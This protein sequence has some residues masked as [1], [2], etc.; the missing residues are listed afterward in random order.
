MC[1]K[2]AKFL[3]ALLAIMKNP[4]LLNHVLEDDVVWQKQIE[5]ALRGSQLP[6]ANQLGF[7][8]LMW[9]DLVIEEARTLHTYA[10]LDGGSL[11]TD[12]MLLKSLAKRIPQCDYFEIGTWRGESAVNVAETA[13]SVS[14][15]NLSNDTMKAMGWNQKYIDLHGFFSKPSSYKDQFVK[16]AHASILHIQGNTAEFDF[17]SLNKKYDLIFIDGDHHFSMVKN[18]TLKVMSNLIHDN[19][20]VVWHDYAHSP[21]KARLEVMA[22]IVEGLN[23]DQLQHIYHVQH[24]LCAIYLPEFWINQWNLDIH[25][26]IQQPHQPERIF[27]VSVNVNN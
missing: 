19:S 7:R 13:A 5:R 11:P 26:V 12:L 4:W 17:A 16:E 23:Q 6:I 10:M 2:I 1:N 3:Q 27:N 14:T 9:E 15:M 25:P 24:T 8:S 20:I 22:G 21:E 18:D